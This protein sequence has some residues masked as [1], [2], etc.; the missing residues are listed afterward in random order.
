MLKIDDFKLFLK[1][2]EKEQTKVYKI[3]R[4]KEIMKRIAKIT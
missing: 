4:R 3:S 1:K 2:L